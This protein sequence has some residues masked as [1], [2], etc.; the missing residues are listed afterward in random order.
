[1]K[2]L[3]NIL[4][5][6]L[7][8][9]GKC[10]LKKGIRFKG[11][12]ESGSMETDSV[13]RVDSALVPG[14]V[15]T[16]TLGQKLFELTD[17]LSN[18]RTVVSDR[19]IAICDND[20]VKA[21]APSIMSANDYYPFHSSLRSYEAGAGYRYGGSGGQEKDN[22]IYG[23]GNSYTAE[24]WQ[25]DA[26]VVTRWNMD[27]KGTQGGSPYSV[28]A[29]NPIAFTDIKGD[30]SEI[31][32]LSGNHL[33]RI[34]D[35]LNN[36][37]I[38]I[39]K[40]LYGIYESG[41]LNFENDDKASTF[42]RE[43]AYGRITSNSARRFLHYLGGSV[44]DGTEN[45]G[46]MFPILSNILI[47]DNCETCPRYD[48]RNMG[49]SNASEDVQDNPMYKF[50]GGRNRDFMVLWHTHDQSK[51]PEADALKPSSRKYDFGL[52][53]W[54]QDYN[55]VLTNVNLSYPFEGDAP[56]IIVSQAGFTV[57]SLFTINKKD[58]NYNEVPT[59]DKKDYK[60]I[61]WNFLFR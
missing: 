53:P 51:Y 20:T 26:R 4:L 47:P 17:H 6:S 55:P 45:G 49:L 43:N 2:S 9:N 58:R 25:Y 42:L 15:Y 21:W 19:K 13:Y 3:I 23:E 16:R 59:E 56:A 12:A 57:Y 5:R 61:P 60:K 28:F 31:F 44:Q 48:A 36:E 24:Y 37:V 54:Y 11:S 50:F 10:V 18:V 46:V 41:T 52:A 34:N 27:P 39:D 32:D 8:G 29:N 40:D 1:M 33:G 7:V 38:F 35:Q 22:E 14:Y 30:T